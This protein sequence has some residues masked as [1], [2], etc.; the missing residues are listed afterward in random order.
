MGFKKEYHIWDARVPELG[1]GFVA[2]VENPD[3]PGL[4]IRRLM[5]ANSRVYLEYFQGLIHDDVVLTGDITPAY[6][7]LDTAILKTIKNLLEG[8]GFELKV[9][10]LLRDPAARVWSAEKMRQRMRQQKGRPAIDLEQMHDSYVDALSRPGVIARTSYHQTIKNLE[11][12][13]DDGQVHFEIYED[14]FNHLAMNRLETFINRK[15]SVS[16]DFEERRGM[17]TSDYWAL[18]AYLAD[19]AVETF[20]DQY[21]YCYE[22]FPKTT[23][24]WKQ[25]RGL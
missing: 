14:M 12:V 5:Q 7:F 18:P 19:L 6:A 15:F 17:V 11:Q 22:R 25:T 13:F 9:I 2:K 1:S 8:G 20:H 4:A 24:L 16:P 21:E 23:N 3:K 10:F